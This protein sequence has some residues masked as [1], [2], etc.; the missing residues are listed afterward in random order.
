M[1]TNTNICTAKP[2]EVWHKFNENQQTQ[3]LNAVHEFLSWHGNAYEANHVL[4][5]FYTT[6]LESKYLIFKDVGDN[7]EAEIY[8]KEFMDITST[9]QCLHELCL[10]LDRATLEAKK[11]Y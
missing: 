4:S 3:I 5:K 6:F 10:E 7:T 9:Y 2:I 1:E 11:S 8:Y